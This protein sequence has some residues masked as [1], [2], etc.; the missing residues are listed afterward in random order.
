MWL[1]LTKAGFDTHNKQTHFSPPLDSYVC[2][3]TNRSMHVLVAKVLQS[4]FPVACFWRLSDAHE[5]SGGL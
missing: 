2:Q 3:Q 4:A 1:N 5:C